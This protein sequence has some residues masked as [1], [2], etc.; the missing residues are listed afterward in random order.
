MGVRY[1]P[2]PIER[3]DFY[4]DFDVLDLERSWN[5]GGEYFHS[6][7][8]TRVFNLSCYYDEI[9]IEQREAILRWL[10]RRTSGSLVF[11]ARPY[12]SYHVRPTKK[13]EFKDYLQYDALLNRELYSGTFTITFSAYD[14]FASL[15]VNTSEDMPECGL[16]ET[17]VLP[18]ACMPAAPDVS[19]LTNVY[20]YNPGTEYGHTIIRFAGSVGSS[21]F[22]I[23]NST[24]GDKCVLKN[25]L[26][27]EGD[28]YIEIDSKTGRVVLVSGTEKR[29]WFAYHDEG[30]IRLKSALPVLRNVSVQTSS[31]SKLVTSDVGAF[32]PDMVGQYIWLNGTWKYVS[33]YIDSTTIE[34]NTT[35]TTTGKVTAHIATLNLLTITKASDA[36][37]ERLEIEC[38]AE[39]R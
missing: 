20:V 10:D 1:T 11:D 15:T 3:G 14:P 36:T 30:Y 29:L 28:D 4:P 21:D 2:D 38:K 6:R 24:T 9:T 26:A 37:V 12:A 18:L 8:K 27:T 33:N 19:S 25:G 17:G 31:G 7:V 39:V 34:T 35:A 16:A 13:I 32:T 23:Y 22:E 5:S